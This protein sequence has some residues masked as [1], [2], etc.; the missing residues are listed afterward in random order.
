M[1]PPGLRVNTFDLDPGGTGLGVAQLL[2]RSVRQVDDA[3]RI[4][5]ATVVN[6]QNHCLT[7]IQIGYL[8][9]AGQRQGLVRGTH[10]V[11]VIYLAI[12]GVLTMKFGAIPGRSARSHVGFELCIGK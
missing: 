2:G 10:A 9:V 1:S 6:P 4:E 7:V 12:G 5:R 11:Q 8:D 3:V